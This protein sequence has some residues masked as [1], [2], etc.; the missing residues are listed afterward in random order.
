MGTFKSVDGNKLLVHFEKV[1]TVGIERVTWIQRN[2]QGEKIGSVSQFPII[3]GYAVTCHKSQ[4][5][6]LPAV[7]LHSSK[8]FVAG[9]VY[10]A[11]SQVRSAD[12]L[13][14]ASQGGCMFPCSLEKIRVSPLFPKNK[15]RCS[16]E[17]TLIKFPCSQKFCCMFP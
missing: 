1:G 14:R 9:L 2:R 13:Q 12:T 15:L 5:L 11:M 4:G 7:V 16:L 6:E 8:E 17:F 10:V 3:L